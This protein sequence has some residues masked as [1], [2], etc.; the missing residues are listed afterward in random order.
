MNLNSEQVDCK[1]PDSEGMV[2]VPAHLPR[3]VPSIFL[4][5]FRNQSKASGLQEVQTA[6]VC[7]CVL[8]EGHLTQP[9]FVRCCS[10]W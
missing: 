3:S 8:A 9:S 5:G 6:L 7:I 1:G 10:D 2:L 4:H